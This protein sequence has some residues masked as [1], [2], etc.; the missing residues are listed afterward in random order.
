M[1][2]LNDE[3]KLQVTK[4]TTNNYAKLYPDETTRKFVIHKSSIGPYK[5][6][7]SKKKKTNIGKN[8]KLN[9]EVREESVEDIQTIN[10]SLKT[11]CMIL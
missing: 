9:I 11:L 1:G 2:L 8:Q 4:R 5:K 6:S 10:F 7:L 3:N